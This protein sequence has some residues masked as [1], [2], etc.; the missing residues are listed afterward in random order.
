M[1]IYSL[2][3]VQYRISRGV[4]VYTYDTLIF[5]LSLKQHDLRR[6]LGL[7]PTVVGTTAPTRHLSFSSFSFF[8]QN[9]FVILTGCDGPQDRN[10]HSWI[11]TV[12]LYSRIASLA[13]V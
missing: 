13:R 6:R 5:H 2:R 7:G 9:Q 1:F 10:E 11:F 8:K 4:V 12:I 3:V